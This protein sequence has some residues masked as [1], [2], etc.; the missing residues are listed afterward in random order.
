MSRRFLDLC[1]DVVSDLG[2]SGGVINSVTGILNAEQVRVINWVARADLFVQNLWV[3]WLFLWVADS[4]VLGQT[5]SDILTPTLPT[6]ARAIPTI[7]EDSLWMSAGTAVARPIKFLP[8]EV[9][10]SAFE[11]KAKGTSAVPVAYSRR[12]DGV[13]VLSHKLAQDSTFTLDYHVIGKRLAADNDTSPIPEQF[14]SIIV[15]RSKIFYAERENAPEIM[16]G[17]TAEYTDMLDKMQAV[18]LPDNTAGRRLKNTA[19]PSAYVE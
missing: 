15:E 16:S 17:S 18:Y 13:L 5:G 2:I 9:F 4:A 3:D 10:R 12:P 7:E 14:D 19:T 11:R 8:W 1:K 6:W